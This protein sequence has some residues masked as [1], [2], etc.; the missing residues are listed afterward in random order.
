M[1]AVAYPGGCQ[2]FDI[3]GKPGSVFALVV[4]TPDRVFNDPCISTCFLRPSFLADAHLIFFTP[5]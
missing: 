1:V 5:A 2:Q 3:S 4:R